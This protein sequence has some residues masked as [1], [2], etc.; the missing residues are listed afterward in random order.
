MSPMMERSN[1]PYSI[2]LCGTGRPGAAGENLSA[3]PFSMKRGLSRLFITA[4]FTFDAD[5]GLVAEHCGIPREITQGNVADIT[6]NEVLSFDISFIPMQG[7]ANFLE[8]F[9]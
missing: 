2:N 6:Q 3:G 4:G 9:G 1:A 7:E 5:G 8:P